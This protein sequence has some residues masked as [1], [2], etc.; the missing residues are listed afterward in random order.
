[1]REGTSRRGLSTGAPHCCRRKGLTFVSVHD[2]FW[3]HAADVA[4]MNQVQAHPHEGGHPRLSRP[5]P[6]P[7]LTWEAR[8]PCP[9]GLVPGC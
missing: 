2:C 7:L 6:H 1:M 8:S 9:L 4:V 3:T 5:R